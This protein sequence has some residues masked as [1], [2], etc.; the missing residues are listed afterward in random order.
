MPS[1]PGILAVCTAWCVAAQGFLIVVMAGKR[2]RWVQQ[3]AATAVA[4]AIT[5]GRAFMA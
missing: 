2:S 1:H 4:G 3:P 5:A